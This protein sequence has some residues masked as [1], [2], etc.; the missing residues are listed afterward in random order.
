VQEAPSGLVAQGLQGA[1]E[2]AGFKPAHPI[3]ELEGECARCA[4]NPL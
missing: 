2:H 4:S 1:A 3:V